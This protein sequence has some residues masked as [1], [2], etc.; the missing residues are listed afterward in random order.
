MYGVG[1]VLPATGPVVA[2]GAVALM[3]GTANSVWIMIAAAT[4]TGMLTWG[5]LYRKKH[6][7]R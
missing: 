4:A 2:A 6:A 5:V 7:A 3:P 1:Q